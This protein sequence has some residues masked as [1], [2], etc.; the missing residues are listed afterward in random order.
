MT[1]V[2]Y[3]RHYIWTHPTAMVGVV[4]SVTLV[5][6]IPLS[7]LLVPYSP[8]A[9]NAAQGLLPPS[10]SHWFG[11]DTNGTDV[12]SRVLYAPGSTW[13]SPYPVPPSR[14]LSARYSA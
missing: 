7:P 9:P 6:L 5:L 1:T 10:P 14:L 2:R 12:F 3:L 13:S 11:T 4:I 8:T